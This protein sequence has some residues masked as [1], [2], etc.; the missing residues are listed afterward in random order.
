[1]EPSPVE[2]LTDLV[3]DEK[4]A[5]IGRRTGEMRETSSGDGT[6][7]ISTFT[8]ALSEYDEGDLSRCKGV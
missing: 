4:T 5:C 3:L 7:P 2:T 1:M 8:Q 6:G